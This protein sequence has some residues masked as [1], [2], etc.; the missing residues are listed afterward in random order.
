[1]QN[2][3]RDPIVVP[4]DKLTKS[5]TKTVLALGGELKANYCFIKDGK[6][7]LFTE[8]SDLKNPLVYQEFKASVLK[9]LKNFSLKPDIIA[10]D[11]NP[12]FLSTRFAL[13]LKGKIFE[14]SKIINIQHH[15][16]HIAAA[17]AEN[18][19]KPE[20]VIGVAC[21]GTGWG[22]DGNVWGCEFMRCDLEKNF[23]FGHLDYMYLPGSEQAIKEPWRIAF[24]ML[25][26]IY[27]EKVFSLPIPW[28]K[29]HKYE[30]KIMAQMIRKQIN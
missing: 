2:V 1:M 7:Y 3:G 29:K 27:K 17:L 25:F 16:A 6:A 19:R 28:L 5:R 18:N 14:K 11:S 12:V 22:D 23:R 24:G 8:F 15:Y 9:Q 30:T 21:D 13:E 4:I 26:K 10:H 20:K